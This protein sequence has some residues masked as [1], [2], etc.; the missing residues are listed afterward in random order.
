MQ[1]ESSKKVDPGFE[2]G[3]TEVLKV[4]KSGAIVRNEMMRMG[5][6][7]TRCDTGM[8]LANGGTLEKCPG[9]TPL[10]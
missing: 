5:G 8:N 6:V 2:P 9:H 4:S 10:H 7:P 3:L 1:K